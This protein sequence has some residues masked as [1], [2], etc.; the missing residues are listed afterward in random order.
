MPFQPEIC[1][2]SNLQLAGEGV[3][4]K[5]SEKLVGACVALCPVD[6]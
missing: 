2:S 5:R 3:V 6:V 4:A 1:S